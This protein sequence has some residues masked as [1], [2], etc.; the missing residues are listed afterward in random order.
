MVAHLRRAEQD[1]GKSCRILMDLAGPK[2]RTGPVEPGARVLKWRP[3]RDPYGRVIAPARIWLMPSDRPEPPPSR[4][5]ASAAVPRS[6]DSR[7][8]RR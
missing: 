4:A 6:L 2:L 3:E 5:D 8:W 7:A 1:L